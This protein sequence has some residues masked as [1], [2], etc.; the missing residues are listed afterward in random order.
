M[1]TLFGRFTPHISSHQS[2]NLALFHGG[3]RKCL[4]GSEL[5]LIEHDLELCL[6][7]K[8]RS[9]CQTDARGYQIETHNREDPKRA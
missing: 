6:L 7:D 2:H 3:A 1:V 8:H 5:K 4:D 9:E